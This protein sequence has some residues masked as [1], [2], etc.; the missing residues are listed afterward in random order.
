MVFQMIE[1][2]CF[3]LEVFESKIY[4]DDTLLILSTSPLLWTL[5]EC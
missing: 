1:K 4:Y 2:F 3:D 5:M